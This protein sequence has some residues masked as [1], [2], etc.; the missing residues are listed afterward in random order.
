MINEAR[1]IVSCF[2]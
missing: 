1:Y 2:K